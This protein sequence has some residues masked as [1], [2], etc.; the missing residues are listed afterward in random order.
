MPV[1]GKPQTKRLRPGAK[2]HLSEWIS[3][4]Q[5]AL[6]RAVR[7]I[8]ANF[9]TRFK[10]QSGESIA[11]PGARMWLDLLVASGLGL[12]AMVYGSLLFV[13]YMQ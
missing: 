3:A 6:E 12:P 8:S 7:A 11:K 4:D 10:A 1:S 9:L 13:N 2:A 5:T